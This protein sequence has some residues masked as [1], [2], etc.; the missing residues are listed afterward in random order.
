MELQFGNFDLGLPPLDMQ[1][2]EA[3][4]DPRNFVFSDPAYNSDT[5]A[6]F[7]HIIQPHL[8]V[9]MPFQPMFYQAPP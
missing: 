1:Q 6:L 7:D 8:D 2:L 5:Q 9:N 4:W 3:D